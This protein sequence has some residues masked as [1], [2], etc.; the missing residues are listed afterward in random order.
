[1]RHNIGGGRLTG[2]DLAGVT[3]RREH[4][5]LLAMITEPD[6]MIKTDRQPGNCFAEFMTPMLNMGVT[7]EEARPATN[8]CVRKTGN[9]SRRRAGVERLPPHAIVPPINLEERDSCDP[10]E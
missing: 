8:T 10:T 4:G 5:W 7:P 6:S 9:D 2:P 3:K 1:M